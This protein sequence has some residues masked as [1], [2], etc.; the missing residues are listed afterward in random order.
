MSARRVVFVCRSLAG[1]ASR[2][3]RAIQELD[4]V[5]LLTICVE[6]VDDV[7]GLIEA[8]RSLGGINRIVTAQEILLLPVAAANEAL[9]LKAMTAQVVARTLDKSKLKSTLRQAGVTTPRDQ[10]IERG[11]DARRFV[12]EVGFPIVLKPLN[13]SGALTTFRITTEQQLARI[14]KLTNPPVIAETHVNGQELCFDTVT[15]ANEP[16]CYSVC[17]YDPPI[18]DALESPASRWRCIMPRDLSPYKSFIDQGLRAV[19]ALQ[20]GNAMTHMEGF[21]DG[22]GVPA[23]FVDATLR[24]AGARI[25][26]MFGFAYDVDP[27]RVWARVAVDDAFDGPLNRKYAVG[28]IFLRDA[29]SGSVAIVDGIETV[30]AE[31]NSMIVETRWPRIGGP[32][33]A[34]YTGD[35]FVT[36]RHPDTSV[37]HNALDFI[38]RTIRI[39]YSS[40]RQSET[41]WSERMDNF[42]ELNKPAWDYEVVK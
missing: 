13:G 14:L 27:Y 31:L 10:I 6:E 9:G 42:R 22:S 41:G 39:T 29:G 2:C 8:A 19:R 34:T 38:D 12:D 23:G 32:K 3:A 36:V 15:I 17:C 24:P 35:G 26:P 37:V 7:A 20:V 25:G 11:E 33:S 16:Q 40:S 28:T 21:I 30:T 1:E 4:D 5:T 18:I